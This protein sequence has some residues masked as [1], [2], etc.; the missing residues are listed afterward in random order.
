MFTCTVVLWVKLPLFAV[1]VTALVPLGAFLCAEIVSVVL[2]EPV[3]VVGL[4]VAD[5]RDG[6]P[7]TLKL[8]LPANPFTEPIVTD[9]DPEPFLRTVKFDGFAETVKSGVV[10]AFTVSDAATLCDPLLP[11]PVIE[12]GYEPAGVDEL[13]VTDNVEPFPL[14]AE[15][16]LNVP[17]APVGRPLTLKFTVPGVPDVVLVVTA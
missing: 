16:G 12:I 7:L 1:I 15:V 3:T 9:V 14:V 5:V 17:F 6:K 4:N 10:F 2:P 11:V 13:V 8:T